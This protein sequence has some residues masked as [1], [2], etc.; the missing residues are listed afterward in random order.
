[1]RID[2][3]GNLAEMREAARRVLPALVFDFIDGGVED[4]VCLERNAAAFRAVRLLPRYLV[5]MSSRSRATTLFGRSHASPF[6]ICPMGSCGLARPGADLALA[7]AAAAAQIPF[8]LS[9]GT[10]ASIEEIAATGPGERWYQLY[11]A[12]DWAINADFLRRAEAAGIRTVV[13]TID[14]PV[15]SLRERSRRHLRRGRFAPTPRAAFE[16]LL[17][18][19]WLARYLRSGGAPSFGSWEAYFDARPVTFTQLRTQFP[20]PQSW[21]LIDRVR[22]A[23]PH[24]LVVKGV[25]H[26]EDAVRAVEA[27]AEGVIVSNHGGRQLDAA[28]AAFEALPAIVQAVGD[29]ATV[30][31][32]SGV[33]RGAHVLAALCMGARFVFLGRPMLY[34]A[35]VAGEAGVKRVID[36]LNLEIDTAMAQIGCLDIPGLGPAFLSDPPRPG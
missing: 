22:A 11:P 28:P 15:S 23:W 6:G 27:G 32:D 5:D 35:A 2:D 20:S 16:A 12:R 31:L 1:L 25:L 26:P 18:P 3:I 10:N 13:V 24:T 8:I 9:S 7:R 4:E 33:R 21:T 17:H 14:I 29:R 36:M 30:M 19:G 34:G